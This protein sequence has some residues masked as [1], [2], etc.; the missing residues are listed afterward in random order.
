MRAAGFRLASDPPK[1]TSSRAML[2]MRPRSSFGPVQWRVRG[3]ALFIIFL[4]IVLAIIGVVA[5][6]KK[7]L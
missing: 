7:V 1:M 3:W 2:Q 5:I 4:V 6:V